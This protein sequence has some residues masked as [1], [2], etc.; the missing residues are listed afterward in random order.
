MVFVAG[1]RQ[2]GKTTLARSL[3]GAD[4][5]YLNWDVAE[6]REHIL[7]RELPTGDLWVFDE[8]HK[9]RD[10]RNYL[11]GLYDARA[12]AERRILVVG[13]A[14]LDAYRFGGDSLQGRFH[15]LRLHPLS[16]AELE[17]RTTGE[18][19]D[20]LVLGGFPEPY[21]GGSELEARRWSREHRTLLIREE[22][23][24][25]ERIQD[26][27]RLELLMLRLPELVGSPLSIN[28]LREDLQ[29][30]HKAVADWLGAFER[31]YAIFRLSPFGA[32]TI[33]AVKK[34][35]KHYHVDWTVVPADAPRFENLVA[36][37]LLKWVHHQQDT[38]GLD[39]EL[40][41]FRDT[42]GRE[43]DFIVTDRRQPV[44]CVECKW[45]DGRLDKSL[46]YFKV[47][48]PDCEAW[49]VSATGTKDFVTPEGIRV[50]PA[51]ELLG[52]LV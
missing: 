5:G 40:R 45:A 28:A 26:L 1:P 20:L 29:V 13:S 7:R 4:D 3:P 36:C 46:R 16:A 33:R 15:L 32:P 35:Q 10:W 41:Y 39:L 37:H 24:S 51:L 8:I 44:L 11:K 34:Q 25:L 38:Q 18:L 22:V 50:A 9:Y 47:R 6:D 21:F 19:Q 23:T 17:L 52:R 42:D 49:Q 27:G 14:R 30:S 48:F 31:L 12:A 2:V 43:V